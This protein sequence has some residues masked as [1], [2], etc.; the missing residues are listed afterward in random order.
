MINK[1]FEISNSYKIVTKLKQDYPYQSNY[2][3]AQK[4]IVEKAIFATLTGLLK[5]IPVIKK[6]TSIPIVNQKVSFL[7]VKDLIVE[8]I[9]QIAFVYGYQ[10]VTE[11][12]RLAIFALVFNEA[13]L[14]KLNLKSLIESEVPIWEINVI[15]N[16]C[17][18]TIIGY[19]TREFYETQTKLKDSPLN[20]EKEFMLIESKIKK[21]SEKVNSQENRNQIEK[22]ISKAENSDKKLVLI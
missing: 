19:A 2:E 5:E 8:V 13:V 11:S 9:H 3:I 22:E 15:S 18:F 7:N 20:S 14:L 17:L 21:E 16:V 1:D 6:L 12:E 10:E 4:L